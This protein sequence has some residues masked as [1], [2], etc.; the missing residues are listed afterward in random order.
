MKIFLIGLSLFFAASTFAQ[1]DTSIPPFKR[2]PSVPGLQLL[3]TD[4]TAYTNDSVP[5][6]KP[7]MLMLFS[8][9]CDH[10]QHEAEQI[11][12]NKDSFTDTHIILVSTFP[13]HRLKEFAEKYRLTSMDNVVITKDPFYLLVSFYAVRNLPYLALYNKKGKL[14]ETFAGSVGIEKIITALKGA[15]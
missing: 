13:I 10:C 3:T 1:Q 5:K 9:D 8:P 14:I 2:Y 12:A 7:V 4:S 15:H 6:N 11:V